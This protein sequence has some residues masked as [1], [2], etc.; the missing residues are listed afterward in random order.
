MKGEAQE[1]GEA[2]S[3]RGLDALQWNIDKELETFFSRESRGRCVCE[4]ITLSL[5]ISLL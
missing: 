1:A 4:R 2:R 3:S 5:E